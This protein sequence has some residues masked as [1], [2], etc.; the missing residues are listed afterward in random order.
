MLRWISDTIRKKRIKNDDIRDNVEVAPIED[1]MGE[2]RL[3]WFLVKPTSLSFS[4][5]LCYFVALLGM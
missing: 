4:T 5:S 1:K 3:R 2:L